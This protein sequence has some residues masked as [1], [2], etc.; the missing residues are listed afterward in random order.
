MA[1]GG[2]AKDAAEWGGAWGGEVEHVRSIEVVVGGECFDIGGGQD[3]GEELE[4]VVPGEGLVGE[5]EVLAL[6]FKDDGGA[7]GE[8]GVGGVVFDHGV[9]DVVKGRNLCGHSV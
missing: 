6:A 3:G 5:E 8:E 4:G 1:E 7:Y 9:E 2:D